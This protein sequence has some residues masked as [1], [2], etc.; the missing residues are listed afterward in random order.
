MDTCNLYTSPHLKTLTAVDD[1]GSVIHALDT[2]VNALESLV[3][4]LETVLEAL[5]TIVD[6]P[7]NRFPKMMRKHAL[8]LQRC[9]KN[10]NFDSHA[11]WGRQKKVS[12]TQHGN[13]IFKHNA[14]T[15]IFT[16]EVLQKHK[17]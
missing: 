4:A 1:L 11:A 3:D 17:Y 8:S 12:A 7:R 15:C 2:V 5:E 13:V 16:A 6:A 9:C 10:G 14:K